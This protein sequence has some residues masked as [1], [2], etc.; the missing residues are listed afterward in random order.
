MDR[1][2]Q[3]GGL[4][5]IRHDPDAL[6]AFYREHV[7]AVQ[8]FVARRVGSP[9]LAADLTAHVFVAAI[10]SAD[11]Y[12]DERGSPAA[13]LYG[14]ARHVVSAEYRRAGRERRALPI[15]GSAL[16]DEDDV[17]AIVARIDAEAGARR[18]RPPRVAPASRGA[19]RSPLPRGRCRLPSPWHRAR[20]RRAS[21]STRTPARSRP[22]PT[23]RRPGAARSRVRARVGRASA[24]TDRRRP[25]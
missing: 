7:E 20:S 11:R 24:R 21:R 3:R 17:A 16:L 10:E 2:G 23:P 12:R 18:R 13:W 6:E 25:R 19:S 22:F 9:E 14:I 1:H 8:R 4:A 5:R 15:A